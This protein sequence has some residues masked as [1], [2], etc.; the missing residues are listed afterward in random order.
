MRRATALLVALLALAPAA[1][2]AEPQDIDATAAIVVNPQTGDVVYEKDAD[3]RHAIAS[4]TKLMTALLTLEEAELDETVT[5]P[6]YGAAPGESIMGLMPGEEITVADLLRAL[7]MASANDAAVALADHVAGGVPAFVRMMNRRAQE[8]GLEDTH[9]ANPIGLDQPGNYSTARDLAALATEL[10]KN[11]FFRRTVNSPEFALRSGARPRTIK[12]R[13]TLL[14][15]YRWVNG[16]KTGYTRQAGNVLVASGR[17]RDVNMLSVVIGA[18]SEL[19]R[20]NESVELLNYG[21]RRFEVETV[22]GD[23]RP[24]ANVPIASRP[25]AELPVVADSTIREARLKRERFE[26]DVYLPDEVEGPIGAGDKVGR[27]VVTLRGR[28]VATADLRAALDVPKASAARRIQDVLT[29]PWILIVLG[30]VLV[31]IALLAY[32]RPPAHTRP[33]EEPA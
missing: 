13:N 17:K 5:A 32:R 23:D 31:G 7:L 28:P 3:G 1:Q 30:A 15:A 19:E 12:N 9:Y 2:A 29:Q 16:I 4:T 6:R 18:P 33:S 14:N 20:N 8:L 24:I 22:V 21:L 27:V 26:R 11:V 25:G 10:R